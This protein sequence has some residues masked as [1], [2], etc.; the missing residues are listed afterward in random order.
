MVVDLANVIPELEDR[1][2]MRAVIKSMGRNMM[3]ETLLYYATYEQVWD[4]GTLLSHT[5]WEAPG[6]FDMQSRLW[7]QNAVKNQ[8]KINYTEPFTDVNTGKI[9]VTLSYR[10]LDNNGK[11]IGVSAADIVLDA[12]SEAVKTINLSANSK[13]NIIT[14]EGL[15]I[16]NEDFKSIMTKNYFDSTTFKSFTKNSYLDGKSKAFIEDGKFYGCHKVGNT[17][18]SSLQKVLQKIF[19]ANT[20]T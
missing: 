10:V 14:S 4:G 8:N 12:L 1:D 18:C 9:I 16:T 6:D 17:D 5:G 19:P 11:L 2:Q 15:Y 13:V 20:C 3:D 7:H